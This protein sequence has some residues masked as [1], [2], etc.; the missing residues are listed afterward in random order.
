[1]GCTGSKASKAAKAQEPAKTLLQEPA[2]EDKD[3][4]AETSTNLAETSSQQEK[5]KTETS[6]NLAEIAAWEAEALATRAKRRR[7][8]KGKPCALWGTGGVAPR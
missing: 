1:M 2:G 3:A 7:Q 5:T 6:A 4:K 8:C